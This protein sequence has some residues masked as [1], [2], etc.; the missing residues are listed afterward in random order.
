MNKTRKLEWG[1]VSN[2]DA[3]LLVFDFSATAHTG[4]GSALKLRMIQPYLETQL[5]YSFSENTAASGQSLS[6]KAYLHYFGVTSNV[7]VDTLLSLLMGPDMSKQFSHL[8]NLPSDIT[9]LVD[10]VLPWTMEENTTITLTSERVVKLASLIVQLPSPPPSLLGSPLKSIQLDIHNPESDNLGVELILQWSQLEQPFT[11]TPSFDL[12]QRNI[13][14]SNYL[15]NIKYPAKISHTFFF[16]VVLLLIGGFVTGSAAYMALPLSLASDIL[17]FKVDNLRSSI[18]AVKLLGD[19]LVEKGTIY[20]ALET[21]DS[22]MTLGDFQVSFQELAGHYVSNSTT[23]T[24]T[25][26][27]L[28]CNLKSTVETI[29]IRQIAESPTV[30]CRV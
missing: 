27:T 16:D 22:T 1:E 25:G 29:V 9:S 17:K 8:K 18:K 12:S 11:L 26:D 4:T 19:Y 20:A 15:Q 7:T 23:M 10:K 30:F 14:L 21:G 2:D 6:L 5:Y 28:M 24:Y 3:T 13:A